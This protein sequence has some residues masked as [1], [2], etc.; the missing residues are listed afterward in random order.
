MRI[1]VPSTPDDLDGDHSKHTDES[2]SGAIANISYASDT[3]AGTYTNG[4]PEGSADRVAVE[5]LSD[6]SMILHADGKNHSIGDVLQ[7]SP[8]SSS[9]ST[10]SFTVTDVREDWHDVSHL[11]PVLSSVDGGDEFTYA[12]L[13]FKDDVAGFTFNATADMPL[14]AL[15]LTGQSVLPTQSSGALVKVL[16][17][18]N[19]KYELKLNFGANE[20]A[21][22]DR[23]A[24]LQLQKGHDGVVRVSDMVMVEW[25][26]HSK[27]M[28]QDCIVLQGYQ[29]I[30]RVTETPAYESKAHIPFAPTTSFLST[31]AWS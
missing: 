8:E 30:K 10:V 23:V 9:S 24:L 20:A 28:L 7:L 6:G 3:P 15:T 31:R 16:D 13:A 12:V 1:S 11:P 29:D 14:A 4:Q 27:I 25:A 2:V 18:T 26:I 5:I 17:T 21:V 19:R 22:G